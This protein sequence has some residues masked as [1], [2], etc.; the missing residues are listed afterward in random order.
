MQKYIINE[1]SSDF[2]P[3]YLSNGLIGFRIG[4]NP[5]LNGR[6]FINGFVGF[7][8]Q[9]SNEAYAPAPYPLGGNIIFNRI[10]LAKRPDLCI[11]S[12]QSY[13]FSNGELITNLNFSVQGITIHLNILTF[14]SRTMPTLVLQETQISVSKPCEFILQSIMDFYGLPGKCLFR[15]M[16][17]AIA[18]AVLHWE[19]KKGFSTCGVAFTSEFLGEDC[20][21]ER[22]NDWG[23]E[24]GAQI[25]EYTI[26]GKPEKKYVMRQIGSLV[27]D[28]MNQDP[29]WQA[30]RLLES[31]S[32]KG[33][34]NIRKENRA[35]WKE[36]WKGRIKII[37]AE[38]KWQDISDASY[39]YIH[40]SIH[41]S[42]PCSIAPFGLG[43]NENY[44]GHIFWDAETFMFPVILLTAPDS[45]KSML[46]YRSRMFLFAKFNA[47][48]NGYKGIQF[49]W[50]SGNHGCELTPVWA[51]G[52]IIEQHIN[53]DIAFAFAMYVHATGDEN[54]LKQQAWPVIEGVAE[55]ICSRVIKTKR[56]YEIHNVTGPDEELVNVNNNS[57]TNITALIILRETIYFAKLL[58]LKPLNKWI[59]IEKKMFIPINQKTKII[60]KN[61]IYKYKEGIY[62]PETLLGFFPFTYSHSKKIDRNTYMDYLKYAGTYLGMPMFSSLLGVYAARIGNRKLSYKMFESG[63]YNFI[64]KP[65][66]QFVETSE[67]IKCPYSIKETVFLTNPAGFLMSCLIGLSGIQ[68]DSQ[69]PQNWGKFPVIMPEGWDG[70]EVERIWVRGKQ[71]RLLAK[72]G[73]KKAKIEIY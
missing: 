60:L 56:G 65:F 52:G 54:F 42:T 71:A 40:S 59:D 26:Q 13:D 20:I 66:S 34:D 39:F 72:H 27:P 45:A 2:N 67:D 5:F 30:M 49:P 57:Y 48:L 6:A 43:H 35:A 29:H 3:A 51:K 44:Y 69:E 38:Q 7:L 18:D 70:I 58:G 61:D 23:Y 25:K 62:N 10:S 12:N 36:L 68:I 53:M 37:G 19:S 31:A 73:D 63:I 28:I 11:F 8:E 33:F 17:K 41:P 55:W 9:E 47:M 15:S 21:K 4:Q 1:Y 14:C 16:P 24:Q 64:M 22:R 32:Y 46:D 50:Q